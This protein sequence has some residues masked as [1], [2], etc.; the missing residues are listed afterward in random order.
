MTDGEFSVYQF[1]TDES[2][3]PVLRFVDAETAVKCSTQLIKSIGAKTGA[4]I[5]VII[6]DGGDLTN[7]EWKFGEGIVYPKP[8]QKE[9]KQ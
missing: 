8:P 1:F 3:E 7:F 9:T 5:K 6:T 4:V 2:Y